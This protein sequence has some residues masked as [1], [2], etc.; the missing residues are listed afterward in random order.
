MPF[1]EAAKVA[2]VIAFNKGDRL[3]LP[4]P[5]DFSKKRLA[6]QG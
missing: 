5:S 4:A 2:I 3:A 1:Y 6:S